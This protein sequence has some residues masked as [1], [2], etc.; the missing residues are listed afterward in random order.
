MG[1]WGHAFDHNDDA[2]DLLE[3]VATRRDWSIVEDRIRTY[4]KEGG[5][6]DAQ[7]TVAA[8]EIVAAA[9][10]EPPLD[11]D[12][13]IVAWAG[14]HE[15]QAATL[16]DD[17]LSAVDLVVESSELAELWHEDDA[18]EEDAEAWRDAMASLRSRLEG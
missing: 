6:E 4:V 14:T 10:G 8:L 12:E 13:D 7:P 1:T 3:E 18:D 17:A 16:R 2:A 9:L 11:M 5:Y 15:T